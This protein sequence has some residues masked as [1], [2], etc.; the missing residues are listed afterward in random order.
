MFKYLL[1]VCRLLF[2][3]ATVVNI[4]GFAGCGIPVTMTQLCAGTET[5][6]DSL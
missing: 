2:Q 5:A 4:L 6:T 3:R 1:R